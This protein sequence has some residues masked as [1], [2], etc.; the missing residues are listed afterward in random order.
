MAENQFLEIL[1]AAWKAG[2]RRLAGELFSVPFFRSIFLRTPDTAS[3][4]ISFPRLTLADPQKGT[5]LAQN[6]FSLAGVTLQFANT[7]EPWAKPAP[8]RRFATRLHEFSWMHDLLALETPE[9][10]S[11]VEEHMDQWI[12]IYGGWN[13]FSWS[14]GLAAKRCLNWLAAGEHLLGSG[15]QEERRRE[16]LIRQVSYLLSLGNI[17]VDPRDR[18]QIAQ[19]L[20]ATGIIIPGTERFIE[21][22]LALLSVQLAEQILPDGGHISRSPED[23]T[24]TLCDLISLKLLLESQNMHVPEDIE[25]A[26]ARLAPMVRFLCAADGYLAVFNG[27]GEGRH[28]AVENIL[29]NL[30]IPESD[31]SYAPHSGY[32]RVRTEASVL[33]MDTGRAPP[34]RF[35]QHAHAGALA[36]ELSTPGGRLIVNCGWS[37]DQPDRWH[38]AVRTSAAHS[39]LTINDT[40]SAQIRAEGLRAALLGPR[41]RQRGQANPSRRKL[42]PGEGTRIEA[43]HGGYLHRY[44]LIH[45]RQVLVHEGGAKI[46]GEDRV[47]RPI[48]APKV[49]VPPT[50]DC[51]VRFHLHP[52]VRASLAR[53]GSQILLILPD[54]TGWRFHC[55]IG[56]IELQ[57]SVYLAAGAPPGRTVQLVVHHNLNTKGGIT[58]GKNLISWSIERV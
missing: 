5:A 42:E 47:F 7:R 40:S 13:P 43:S 44:G 34:E 9:A 11:L 25:R 12:S 22:G 58:N 39:T 36:L 49:T 19:V 26:L 46:F 55:A 57:P 33:I 38:A 48:D 15:E 23:A 56:K 10:R 21:R 28:L 45:Q 29:S 50:L 51:A 17:A 6:T 20:V 32:Q 16:N 53:D 14:P 54:G 30:S 37:E 27:S 18:L 1:N 2:R 41:L 8:S 31:F 3:P 24:S 52:K 35:S 4:N